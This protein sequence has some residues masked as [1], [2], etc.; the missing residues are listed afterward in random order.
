MVVWF[1]AERC[2]FDLGKKVGRR[3]R[4]LDAEF[5]DLARRRRGRNEMVQLRAQRLLERVL[6]LFELFTSCSA[7][8]C[9]CVRFLFLIDHRRIDDVL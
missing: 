1:C 7:P 5:E 9:L 6:F 3:S 4:N 8:L 2:R